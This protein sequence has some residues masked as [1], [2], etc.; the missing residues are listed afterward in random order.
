MKVG[1]MLGGRRKGPRTKPKKQAP[2]KKKQV[3]IALKIKGTVNQVQKAVQQLASPDA[4][5]GVSPIN[6]SLPQDKI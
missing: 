2:K 4:A 5:K 3:K 1:M 6:P